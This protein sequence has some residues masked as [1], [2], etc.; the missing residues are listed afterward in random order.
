MPAGQGMVFRRISSVE[1]NYFIPQ[2][3]I[4]LSSWDEDGIGY[5]DSHLQNY[6]KAVFCPKVIMGVGNYTIAIRYSAQDD[7][8]TYS[9]SVDNANYYGNGRSEDS[10]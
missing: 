7:G 6:G 3:R 10:M 1:R 2:R 9:V 5:I 8:Q 4:N